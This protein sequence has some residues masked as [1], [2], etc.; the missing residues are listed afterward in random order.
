MKTVDA[1]IT[2]VN[3]KYMYRSVGDVVSATEKSDLDQ[4]LRRK[5]HSAR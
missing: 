5:R 1:V 3:K 4:V 2:L